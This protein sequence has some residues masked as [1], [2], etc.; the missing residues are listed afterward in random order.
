MKQ[1]TRKS[2]TLIWKI[3]AV[4]LQKYFVY[5]VE[6]ILQLWLWVVYD[7]AHDLL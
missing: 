3:L 2:S 7:D 5:V 1:K 6:L 4:I